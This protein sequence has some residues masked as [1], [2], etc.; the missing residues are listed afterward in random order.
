MTTVSSFVLVLDLTGETPR[1]LRRF[2]Q[3]RLQDSVVHNRVVKGR[4]KNETGDMDVDTGADESDSDDELEST[5]LVVNISRIAISHD[6]QWLATSDD[7]MRTHIFN[8]DS[9]QVGHALLSIL[10]D[11]TFFENSI[12]V[13]YL[14][15]LNRHRHWI[16]TLPVQTSLSWRFRTTPSSFTML[17]VSNFH[18]GARISA[19]PFPKGSHILTSQSLV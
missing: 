11:L 6:G 19:L 10:L 13:F 1:V 4:R 7:H 2:A 16:L 3:H 14:R 12:T 5:P 8:L 18:H 17:K 15:F 9:I